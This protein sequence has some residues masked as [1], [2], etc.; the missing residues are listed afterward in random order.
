MRELEPKKCKIEGQKM[1]P[2]IKGY[3][4]KIIVQALTKVT[5]QPRSARDFCTKPDDC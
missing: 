5:V 2:P 4:N 3:I 1:V